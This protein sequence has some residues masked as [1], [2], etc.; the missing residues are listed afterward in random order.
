MADPCSAATYG[1]CDGQVVERKVEH[2]I[3]SILL[4]LLDLDLV[5]ELS[6]SLNIRGLRE[7]FYRHSSTGWSK[8]VATLL[9]IP[10]IFFG[11]VS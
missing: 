11:L 4:Q 1:H 10:N 3:E 6:G 7:D 8:E 2:L 5:G 9:N